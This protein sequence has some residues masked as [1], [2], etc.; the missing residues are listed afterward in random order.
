MRNFPG[1]DWK[2]TGIEQETNLQQ[3]GNKLP[4]VWDGLGSDWKQTGNKQGANWKKKTGI[5]L[6]T[7]REQTAKQ[8]V[9]NLD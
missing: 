5:R 1:T 3:T 4:T 9:N 7:N 2:E 8:A 6:K